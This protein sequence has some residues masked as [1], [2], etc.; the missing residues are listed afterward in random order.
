V[1][2]VPD[3]APQSQPQPG[4]FV[5]PETFT[6]L[7][8]RCPRCRGNVKAEDGEI[9]CLWCGQ[10]LEVATVDHRGRA[11]EFCFPG[12]RAPQIKKVGGIV[13]LRAQRDRTYDE[14]ITGRAAR[15]LD[16]IPLFPACIGISA[17]GRALS[18]SNADVREAIASLL[19]VGLIEKN[20]Y[21][22]SRRWI[23]Y[24]LAREEAQ[25]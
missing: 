1:V 18:L 11:W 16:Q 17:I 21:G 12:Y 19:S 25:A 3:A 9:S 13:K 6:M 22:D 8:G 15:V 4:D 24:C 10:F 14:G 7:H 23:G 2:V 5:V 20:A